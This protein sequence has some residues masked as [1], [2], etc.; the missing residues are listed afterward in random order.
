MSARPVVD[1]AGMNVHDAL[2]FGTQI[3]LDGASTDRGALADTDVT[4]RLVV[5]LLRAVEGQ[6][7][8]AEPA[9]VVVL[10]RGP[11]GHSAALVHGESWV[12]VH[13]FAALRSV[14]LQSV[15][16]RELPLGR[17]TRLFLASYRVGRFQSSVRGR[18]TLLPRAPEELL[19]TLVG[20]RDYE[21]LRVAPAERV[22]L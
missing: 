20:A 22:T 3:C 16:V 7:C 4:R 18:G 12:A 14:T 11:D 6:D 8:G 21:R 2:G 1:L 5:D 15:S 10:E 9:A 13:A 19:A 17:V